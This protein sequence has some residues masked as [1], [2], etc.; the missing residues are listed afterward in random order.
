MMAEKYDQSNERWVHRNRH[1]IEGAILGGGLY[2][3]GRQLRDISFVENVR[4][5]LEKHA[6][7]GH[8]VDILNDLKKE[9]ATKDS[10]FL[11][12]RDS[13]RK[14]WEVAEREGFNRRP[15]KFLS[16]SLLVGSTA[17]G[18]VWGSAHDRGLEKTKSDTRKALEDELAKS[19]RSI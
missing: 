7:T 12:S 17:I 15:S 8:D 4:N 2:A 19:S 11:P 13:L 18:A 9:L 3:F 1:G 6:V 16:T 5:W 10:E 14:A